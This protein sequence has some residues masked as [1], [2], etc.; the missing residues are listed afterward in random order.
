V[1]GPAS[2][3]VVLASTYDLGRQPFGLASA[4]AWLEAE[5]IPVRLLDLAVEA[6]D[7]ALLADAALIG[8]HL[9]MHTA[10]R[11]AVPLVKRL[12]AINPTAHLAAFGLYAPLNEALLRELGVGTILGG[13]FEAPLLAAARSLAAGRAPA[14]HETIVL[15]KQRFL[16]PVRSGL[17]ELSR[18]AHLIMPDG[19]RRT[20]GFTEATRG[21]KHLCRHCPIVPVYRGRFFVVA[22]ETVLADIRA[23]VSLGAEHISFGDPDFFNGV[24]HALRVAAALHREFPDLTYDATIKVEHLLKHADALSELARTGCLFVTSAVE[25]FDDRTLE[26]LD[27][28]HTAAD[29]ARAVG[30]CRAAGIALSPT[31]V[32]FTPWTTI[33]TYRAMLHAI[34]DLDLI[35]SVAPIQLA[36][37]LLLPQSSLLL[38]LPE[39]RAVIHPFD[40]ESLCHPWAHSDPRVDALHSEVSRLV[41][42]ETEA[43]RSRSAI[44]QRI[45]T[46][47]AGPA[48]PAA[49]SAASLLPVMSEPW[50][51]CAEPTAR[52]QSAY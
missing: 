7:E 22:P 47:L 34:A 35:E 13:E 39:V 5:G 24:G 8:V 10:T 31:F 49:R 30:A 28:G 26:A 27:K 2:C 3:P 41:E 52:Q 14:N 19:T 15:E 9:P 18:Y 46:R 43:G 50:Y 16:P 20:V 17:P 23:L 37:R 40:R 4:A 21:C 12:R 32:A 42:A 11:L 1:S 33:E 6:L 25:S 48:L 45:A 36:I 51:C 29:I 38:D 44:F